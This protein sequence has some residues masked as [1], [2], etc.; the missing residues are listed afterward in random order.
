MAKHTL[1]YRVPVETRFWARVNK[2]GP[3][4]PI[5][6][7]CWEWTTTGG[8]AEHGKNMRPPRYSWQLHNR[9]TIPPGLFVCHHC[10]NPKCV[11]PKHLFLGTQLDNMQ[12]AARKGRT[13][14]PI[15]RVL[16]VA[17]RKKI[18]EANRGRLV[19]ALTRSK[20]SNRLTGIVRSE[21]TRRRIAIAASNCGEETRKKLSEAGKRRKPSVETKAKTSAALKAWWAGNDAAKQAMA[22]RNKGRQV[23]NR[24]AV[25]AIKGKPLSEEHRAKLRAAWVRRKLRG[26]T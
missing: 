10:D 24:A 22:L 1:H 12:D 16:S 11:N 9:K 3:I 23:D 4:H 5:H 19:S 25:A 21:E 14:K 20:I 8:V 7:Q 15:G 26:A 13:Y 18:S 17:T 2:D 6:G